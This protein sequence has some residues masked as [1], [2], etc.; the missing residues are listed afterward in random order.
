MNGSEVSPD[1]P[2]IEEK[3]RLPKFDF[4]SRTLLPFQCT[5]CFMQLNSKAEWMQHEQSH[6]DDEEEINEWYWRCGFCENIL[7]S[8]DDRQNHI[9]DEHFEIGQTLSSWNSST[10][11]YPWDKLSSKPIS[12]FPHWD[13]STLRSMQPT[14][15]DDIYR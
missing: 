3:Y 7:H 2:A 14:I 12:G 15:L 9:A 6:N 11:P 10:S 8:W 5:M 13:V 4:R 1:F